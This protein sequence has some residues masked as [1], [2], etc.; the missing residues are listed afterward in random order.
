MA[1]SVSGTS[2]GSAVVPSVF[3]SGPVAAIASIRPAWAISVSAETLSALEI[4]LSTRTDG[5]CKPRSTWLRYGLDRL[6]SSAS[7]R[8]D[9]FARLRCSW[10][11]APSAS[12]CASHGSVTTHLLLC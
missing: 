3:P 8:S 7:W 12:R 4:A 9:R 1:S 10:M 11:K 2:L 6:V 5:W